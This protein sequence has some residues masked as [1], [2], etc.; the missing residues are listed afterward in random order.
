MK[1]DVLDLH[2]KQPWG[3]QKIKLY[4]EYY[5]NV[6]KDFKQYT[7]LSQICHAEGIKT[8]VE[9]FRRSK[10]V[11]MGALYWQLNDCWPAT[12]WSGIDYY[13]RWKA[14]HYYVKR[15][16]QNILIS[17]VINN[18]RLEVHVVSDSTSD[19]SVKMELSLFDFE[20]NELNSIN[21]KATIS[22][23]ESKMHYSCKIDEILRGNDPRQVFLY[24]ELKMDEK[25]LSTNPL[26]FDL[27]KNIEFPAP[28]I[29]RKIQKIENGFEIK[30]L[31]DKLAR[32][33][34]LIY[35][36]ED[37]FFSD[38]YFDLLPGRVKTITW[39]SD[40]MV[41]KEEFIHTLELLMINDL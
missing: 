13:G 10:P 30:L 41:D 6:P 4:M 12:S 24:C 5:Y 21:K 1:A 26:F 20:G 39:E 25:V 7:Y 17:P 31:S 29:E 22:A 19:I 35:E 3:N 18:D 27:P 28:K 36:K 2:N 11:C 15:F 32:N 8:G 14:L 16:Y 38:N 37:G 23:L 34:G 9:Y 33:V 40:K